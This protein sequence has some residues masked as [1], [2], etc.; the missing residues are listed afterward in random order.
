MCS[1]G[2]SAQ[3]WAAKIGPIVDAVQVVPFLSD[4]QRADI[5][6]R[7]AERFLAGPRASARPVR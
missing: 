1:S 4:A 5:F 6:Y 2:L 7:N 3:E